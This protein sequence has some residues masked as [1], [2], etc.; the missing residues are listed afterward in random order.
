VEELDHFPTGVALRENQTT[1]A[2]IYKPYSDIFGL[3]T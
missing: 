2:V 3:K 1:V